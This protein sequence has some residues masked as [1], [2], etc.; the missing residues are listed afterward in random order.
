MNTVLAIVTYISLTFIGLLFILVTAA[1]ADKVAD[2]IADCGSHRGCWLMPAKCE[3]GEDVCTGIFS[4]TMNLDGFNFALEAYVDDLRSTADIA[5]YGAVGFS[6]DEYMGDDTVI[7][8]TV[9]NTGYGTILLGWNDHTKNYLQFQAT[10][11]M[12]SSTTARLVGDRL[13]CEGR[14][15][16]SGWDKVESPN[17]ILDFRDG[18]NSHHLL[19][20]RGIAD[21]RTHEL[22]AHNMWDGDKFP[23]ITV[24]TIKFCNGSGGVC[25]GQGSMPWV[26]NMH[27]S[28]LP[29]SIRHSAAVSH[30]TLM[31][32]STFVLISTGILT[33]RFGKA[34][35]A[36]VMGSALWFQL[37]RS[38]MFVAVIGMTGGIFLIYWQ[39]HF[40]IFGCSTL[41]ALEDYQK[42]VHAILGTIVYVMMLF[43]VIGGVLRPRL[44]SDWRTSWNWIHTVVGIFVLIA[45]AA[46]CV[47]AIPLGKTGLSY[48]YAK[49]PN[50]IFMVTIVIL[51]GSFA[52]CEWF[53]HGHRY[54][55]LDP[56]RVEKLQNFEKQ[57]EEGCEKCGA[58]NSEK[59]DWKPAI[60]ILFNLLS[61]LA[62]FGIIV[63][64]LVQAMRFYS[65]LL[66]INPSRA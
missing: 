65:Q 44:S 62:T 51:L 58:D 53:I 31:T 21:P 54:I 64:M 60:V 6:L 7:S 48:F 17:R 56:D 40:S 22:K 27:Q 28:G 55:T 15:I 57:I 61:G 47:L 63:T 23:W 12:L 10:E 36:N 32:L 38:C 39:N 20:A 66:F 35:H 52:L 30:G 37:H 25:G 49:T 41:C 11:V 13:E 9:D 43:Q 46:C 50:H 8:C 1:W 45:A 34:Y 33:A 26:T 42:Q 24:E 59:R 3:E 16:F 29:R 5:Y 18:N 14:L 2:S 4:W 19:F